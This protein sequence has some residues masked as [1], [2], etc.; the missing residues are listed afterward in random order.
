MNWFSFVDRLGNDWFSFAL[1]SKNQE[2]QMRAKENQ[3]EPGRAS[4]T[5][6]RSGDPGGFF[7]GHGDTARAVPLRAFKK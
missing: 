4:K 2:N 5:K 1:L 6:K 3:I 7:P